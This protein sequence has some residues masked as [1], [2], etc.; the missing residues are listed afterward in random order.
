MQI[1]SIKEQI[2]YDEWLEA[3]EDCKL[4]LQASRKHEITEKFSKVQQAVADTAPTEL[5]VRVGNMVMQDVALRKVGMQI[6]R[7]S[8]AN[9]SRTFGVWSA[10]N[11]EVAKRYL[12]AGNYTM[13]QKLFVFEVLRSLSDTTKDVAP[14]TYRLIAAHEWCVKR[15]LAAH[16]M[17]RRQILRITETS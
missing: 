12:N 8:E 9:A 10:R 5:M 14:V 7:Y 2:F 11:F 16:P 13:N 15:Y 17:L 6:I 4:F 1:L 3:L